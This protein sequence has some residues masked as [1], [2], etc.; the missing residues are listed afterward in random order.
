M[1]V[2][3]LILLAFVGCIYCDPVKD[4]SCEQIKEFVDGHNSRRQ[5]LL[6]GEVEGQP[7]ASEMNYMVWDKELE[8]KA[9]DWVSENRKYHNPDTD[10]DTGRFNVGENL[11][12]E[13]STNLNHKINIDSPLT[14]WFNEHYDYTYGPLKNSDFGGPKDIAHYTQMAWSNSTYLGCA[15][16]QWTEGGRTDFMVAC[17]YGPGGNFIG[18]RPY[19]SG[20]PGGNLTCSVGD[21]SQP[22]GDRC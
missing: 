20:N 11:Y 17:N 13:Y 1:A 3:V 9:R 4:L 8:D 7:A 15:I 21:C 14:Y 12:W 2:R 22:Y 16:A 19:P 5:Q 10:V 18:Q 6:K